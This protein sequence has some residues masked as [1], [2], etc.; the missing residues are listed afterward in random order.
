MEGRIGTIC[1][2]LPK[3]GVFADVGC[4]HGY[5]A[6]YMLENGLCERAYI[7]DISEKCLEKA[8]KLLRPYIESG[9]CVPVVCDGLKGIP[10]PCDFVLIAGMGGEEIVKILLEGYLPPHFLFQ[11]M[12]NTEKLRRFLIGHGANLQQDLTFSDGKKYYDVLLGA[13][14]PADTYSEREF[15]FGRD[16]LKGASPSFVKEMREELEKT[17]E[18]LR[19]TLKETGR[20]A[21]LARRAELTEIIYETERNL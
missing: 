16:N 13:S 20:A 5:M 19:R 18:R 6:Q 8:E 3:T 12:K 9:K 14:S 15:H 17:E 10:K 1:R 7:S 11:P 21:L 4:D 2:M